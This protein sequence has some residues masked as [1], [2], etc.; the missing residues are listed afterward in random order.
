M[1]T[2]LGAFFACEQT[3]IEYFLAEM[4]IAMKLAI[5]KDLQAYENE[6]IT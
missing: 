1:F 2:G 4:S 3:F 5:S 6:C